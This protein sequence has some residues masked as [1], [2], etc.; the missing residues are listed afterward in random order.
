[1][2]FNIYKLISCHNHYV[3]RWNPLDYVINYVQDEVISYIINN[4]INVNVNVNVIDMYD[5][6]TYL[7]FF[8]DKKCSLYIIQ[9]LI[10]CSN[11][12]INAKDNYE[13]TPLDYACNNKSIDIIIR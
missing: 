3:I 12:H 9:E 4:K 7:D 5:G 6:K 2:K 8:V 13:L 10:N 1:M 11:I